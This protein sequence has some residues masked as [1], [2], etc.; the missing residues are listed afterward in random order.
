MVD[1][2]SMSGGPKI[3]RTSGSPIESLKK[4]RFALSEG[5]KLDQ[6][7]YEPVMVNALKL[8]T[9]GKPGRVPWTQLGNSWLA[10]RLREATEQCDQHYFKLL[11]HELLASIS[12]YPPPAGVFTPWPRTGKPGRKTTTE[13]TKIYDLWNA[14]GCPSPSGNEFAQKA[15]GRKFTAAN[16]M[17]RKRLRDRCRQTVLRALEREIE[18]FR[19]QNERAE[20]ELRNLRIRNERTE[21]EIAK[22]RALDSP[23]T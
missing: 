1:R 11:I 6:P 14:M 23:T 18:N 22:L 13:N 16:G 21:K 2:V 4:Y 8:S 19:I 12:I 3:R 17:E 9:V 5:K 15:F 7:K 20:R 10:V